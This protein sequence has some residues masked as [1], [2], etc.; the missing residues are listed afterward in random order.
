MSTDAQNLTPWTDLFPVREQRAGGL[1]EQV[2][3]AQRVVASWTPERRANVQLQGD[4]F[5]WR[6]A[7]DIA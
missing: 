4:G 6:P 2:R 7:R 1:A 3:D 5:D